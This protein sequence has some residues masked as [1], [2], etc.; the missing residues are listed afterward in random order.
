VPAWGGAELTAA[1]RKLGEDAGHRAKLSEAGRRAAADGR[2]L[3]TAVAAFAAVI[4]QAIAATAAAD[5]YW[6]A[7]ALTALAD[8][9]SPTPPEVLGQWAQ[10]RR[11]VLEPV[12]QVPELPA[13]PAEPGRQA[14]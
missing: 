12:E 2:N 5:G 8:A 10:L 9:T 3:T 4:D 1:L 13:V 6:L 7:D 14:A 11:T